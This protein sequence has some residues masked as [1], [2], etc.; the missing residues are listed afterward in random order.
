MNLDEIQ[1]RESEVYSQVFSR[2]PVALERGEGMY[3]YDI[4][5]RKYLDMFAGIAVN[6]LGHSH[7]RVIRTIREQSERLMHCSNWFYTLPQLELAGLLTK[8]TGMKKAFITNSGT[9]SVEAAIKLA[10]KATGK[11][12]IIAMQ[13]AFHGRTLG[14]LSLTW[15]KNYRKPFL[16]LVP[17]MKFVTYNDIK[18]LRNSITDNTA[19]VILEAI[20]GEAGVL[21]PDNDYLREVREITESMGILLILDEIQTGFGRTGKMFAYEHSGIQPDIVCMAKGMGGGF[22]VGAVT[23]SCTDFDRGEH[24]GTYIGNPLASSVANT[25]INTIIKDNLVKNSATIGQYILDAIPEARGRGLMIGIPVDNGRERVIELIKKGILT[26]YSG[27][28]IRVLPPLIIKKRHA[29][30]FLSVIKD[31]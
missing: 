11:S 16:P 1:R 15:G 28:T 5:G 12:E 29:E 6:S 26:I 18:S 7:P 24:G 31:R 21:L 13:N 17:D 30:E 10:R 4:E 14:A 25:V 9:E 20:Q 19:A 22:P 23:F 27:N 2:L 3:V 8:L